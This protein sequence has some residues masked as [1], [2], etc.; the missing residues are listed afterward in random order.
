MKV[1]L[2]IKPEFAEKI[3]NGSKK[4]EFRRSI[5]KDP[6]VKK[7]IV[8]ASAPISK[9]VGEFEIDKILKSELNT[10]WSKT[11]EYSGISEEYY[12][13]Y[14]EGKKEGYA[15]KIKRSHKY[16]DNLSIKDD[17]GLFPPQSFAYLKESI[18]TPSNY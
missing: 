18:Y 4:Y 5:F 7:I 15:L 11:K 13:K 6:T 12:L 17:F 10:L 14:F 3:F 1:I 16:V 9:I 8:Y 2:S